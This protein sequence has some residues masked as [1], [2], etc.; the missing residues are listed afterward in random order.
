VSLDVRFYR[1]LDPKEL[2]EWERLVKKAHPPGEVRLGSHL[3]W[4]E[5]N[6]ATDYLVRSWDN[7]ELR[8]CAWVT[9]RTV[10]VSGRETAVAGVRGVVTDPEQRRRGHGRTVMERA[11]QLMRSFADCEFA[12]L[13]TSVMAVP[14]YETL[15]WRPIRG[16]VTCDQPHGRIN[17]TET[18]PTAPVMV[19]RLRPWA[20]LP[21]GRVDVR[22]L[23]W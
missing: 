9:Q 5:L 17:Y 14:F 22:G 18:L 3:R 7:D 2:E 4:A 1:D 23:P 11:Q 19:L 20:A 10:S 16:P 13:F 12:L 15:G 21:T 8:A 6:P